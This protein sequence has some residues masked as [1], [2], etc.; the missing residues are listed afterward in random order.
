MAQEDLAPI[1]RLGNPLPT[2]IGRC[3]DLLHD[4]TTLRLK[5]EKEAD[6]IAKREAEIKEHI[7]N[8][9]SA[10]AD[11]GAAGLKYRV[12]VI[13]KRNP[14]LMPEGWGGFTSWMNK[15]DRVDMIQKRLSE[16]PIMEFEGEQKRLPPGLE[17]MN[18]KKLSIT[19]I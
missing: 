1:L 12:Q 2:S 13:P 5:M 10:G 19:K 15:N 14:I 4:V 6:E 3:A 18:V 7:I 16:K 11:T 8:N 17:I 9:L